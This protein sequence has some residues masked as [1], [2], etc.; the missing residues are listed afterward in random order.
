MNL[1]VIN[2]N[3]NFHSKRLLW[4]LRPFNRSFSNTYDVYWE[5]GSAKRTEHGNRPIFSTEFGK[6]VHILADFGKREYFRTRK[7]CNF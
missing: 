6:I 3:N 4:V 5:G 1:F 2:L 7:N